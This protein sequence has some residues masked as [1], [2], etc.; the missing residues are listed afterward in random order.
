MR[1]PRKV[2]PVAHV[3]HPGLAGDSRNPIGAETEL[4]RRYAD[5][6]A[7]IAELARWLSEQGVPTRTG[8]HRWDRSMIRAMLRNPT[9]AGAL[10]AGGLAAPRKNLHKIRAPPSARREGRSGPSLRVTPD[11]RERPEPRLIRP[12]QLPV[13]ASEH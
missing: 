3:D 2:N 1:K 5:E 4:F 10:C 12:W 6:G 7:S 11:P 8:K 9:Y 13:D